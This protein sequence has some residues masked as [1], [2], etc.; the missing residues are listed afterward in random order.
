LSGAQ[1]QIIDLLESEARNFTTGEIAEALGKSKQT[2]SEQAAKLAGNGLVEKPMYGQWRGKG[3][4][5]VSASYRETETPKLDTAPAGPGSEPD[6][7]DDS[8][9]DDPGG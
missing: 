9:L 5:G 2:I 4:F 8:W 6:T 3:S 7:W 1:Q